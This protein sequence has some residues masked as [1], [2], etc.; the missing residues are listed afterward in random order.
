VPIQPILSY[1]PGEGFIH[2]C[3]CGRPGSRFGPIPEIEFSTLFAPMQDH[4]EAEHPTIDS[5]VS[6]ITA[7]DLPAIA[8]HFKHLA[9]DAKR[10][11]KRAFWL[12]IGA[13]VVNAISTGVAV[14]IAFGGG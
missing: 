12:A 10:T 6:L 13:L 9:S 8:A 11:N 4:L 7:R 14:F 3:S 2:E 5:N 1:N